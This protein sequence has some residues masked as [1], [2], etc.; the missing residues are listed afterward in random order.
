MSLCLLSL[1][2][3]MFRRQLFEEIGDFDPD[4]PV[5]EDY[6]LGIRIALRYPYHFLPQPL[7]IKRGGHSD[8]LSRKYWG[9][10]RWRVQALEK[11]LLLAETPADR[12]LI[13]AE[14]VNKS[15]ILL[16]GF[17]KRGKEKEADYYR[18]KILEYSL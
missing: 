3:A 1:S 10:D 11:A 7:I 16:Q 8:Q 18:K 12:D 15:R 9:M 6:D 13:R 17:W 5:C 2:S 4:L 14:I